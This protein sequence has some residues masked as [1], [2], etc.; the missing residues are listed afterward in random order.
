VGHESQRD[1]RRART[2]GHGHSELCVECVG[3]RSPY[4][5]VVKVRPCSERVFSA[6]SALQNLEILPVFLRFCALI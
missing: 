3:L 1:A 5:A 2:Y 6:S 4:Q